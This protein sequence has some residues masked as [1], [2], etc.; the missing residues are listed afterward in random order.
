[1]QFSVEPNEIFRST[2][3]ELQLEVIWVLLSFSVDTLSHYSSYSI[4]E[5]K[6][7]TVRG[8]LVDLFQCSLSVE[9]CL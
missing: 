7:N 1:M 5:E 9:A 6:L 3:R 8:S 4:E 2:D